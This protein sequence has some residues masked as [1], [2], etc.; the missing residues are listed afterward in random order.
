VLFVIDLKTRRV[1]IAG[2][3][4]QPDDDR[5]RQ[6]ARNLTDA[7]DGFL[8]DARFL[9]ILNDEND[10]PIMMES[11]TRVLA[12]YGEATPAAP[13]CSRNVNLTVP[14]VALRRF[15]LEINDTLDCREVSSVV[16]NHRR[17]YLPC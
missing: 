10:L 11:L 8:R 3:W 7:I 2:I 14:E 15:E 13:T 17:A 12:H 9:I 4:H 6:V 16:G 5:M 1:E